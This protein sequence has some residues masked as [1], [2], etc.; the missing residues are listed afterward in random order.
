MTKTKKFVLNIFSALTYLVQLGTIIGAIREIS[1][2]FQQFKYAN[3]SM[4]SKFFVLTN[5]I[6]PSIVN[7][8]ILSGVNIIFRLILIIAIFVIM[9]ELRKMIKNIKAKHFFV[10]D[11]LKRL[12]SMLTMATTAVVFQIIQI[13]ALYPWSA[14]NSP[15]FS[16]F[17]RYHELITWLVEIFF[18]AILYIIYQVFNS[19]LNLK[20]ENNQFI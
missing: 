6:N 18:L 7:Q 12:K 15:H 19:G 13:V 14:A 16:I 4:F 20:K 3:Q 9:F 10:L 5:T 11:N 1:W 2:F 8:K 17:S